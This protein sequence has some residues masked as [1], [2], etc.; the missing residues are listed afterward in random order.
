LEAGYWRAYR[1]FYGWANIARGAWNKPTVAG[2]LRHAAYAVG[3]KKLEPLWD[4]VI[5]AQR[6]ANL[7]PALEAVLNGKVG[8]NERPESQSRIEAV[9]G[10]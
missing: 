3:W 5:R 7:R 2:R 8:R 6:V 4:W 1:N 9:A 10:D